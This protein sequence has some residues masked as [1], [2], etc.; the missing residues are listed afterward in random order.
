MELILASN[1]PRRK[2]LLTDAGYKFTVIPSTKDEVADATL[3]PDEY[4]SALAYDKALNVYEKYGKVV[5]GAD[6]IVFFNGEILGKPKNA[7][8]AKSTLKKLS[9]N[10]H[11]VVTG[12]AVISDKKTTVG[13]VTTKVTFNNLSDEEISAYLNSN[14]WQGKAGS[15]GIQDGF[16]LV[17]NISG[18]YDNVVGLPVKEISNILREFYEK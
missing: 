17:K 11:L 2:K 13:S 12:Y 6:T 10:T 18:D 9:G 14:L 3:P 1:S 15:Y 16:N 5:L 4:A 8:D 7:D